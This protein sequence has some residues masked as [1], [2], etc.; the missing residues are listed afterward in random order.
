MTN[1][2][3]QRSGAFR[4]GIAGDCDLAAFFPARHR[5]TLGSNSLP[6]TITEELSSPGGLAQSESFLGSKPAGAARLASTSLDPELFRPLHA[7]FERCADAQP[8]SIA[9]VDASGA[10]TYGGL[11]SRANR[12]ARHVLAHGAGPGQCVVLLFERSIDFVVAVLAVLKSGAA[13]VPLDSGWPHE[14]QT[15]V[16]ERCGARIV[17]KRGAQLPCPQA[18]GLHVIDTHDSAS[19]LERLPHTRPA[20]ATQPAQLAYVIYTSGSTGEPKGVM[21]EHRSITTHIES[22][23]RHYRLDPSD[24][25]LLFHSTAFDPTIEQLFSA[26]HAGASVRVRGDELWTCREFLALVASADLTVVDLPPRYL[27]QLL[28]EMKVMDGQ[29]DLARLRLVI[30]GGEA[31]PASAV[32]LW[33]ECGLTR[34]RLV[35]SYG[36]TEC[37]V[38]A[39]CHDV[40]PAPCAAELAGR[41]PIGRPH[42]PVRAYVLDRNLKPV[43]AGQK[44]ELCLGGPT[45]GRGYLGQDALTAQRFVDD[46]LAPGGRIYL[47]GDQ[48]RLLADGSIEFLGRFDRQVQVRGYRVELAEIEAQITQYPRVNNAAVV[49]AEDADGT[50]AISAFVVPAPGARID[51]DDLRRHL[52]GRLPGYMMPAYFAEI[53]RLPADGNGKV[54][55]RKLPL[56][57]ARKHCAASALTPPASETEKT[58]LRIWQRVLG[59]SDIGTTSDF[60]ELGGHSLMAIKMFVEIK[61]AFGASLSMAQLF[62]APD[63]QRLAARISNAIAPSAPAATMGPGPSGPWKFL[64]PLQTGGTRPPLFVFAGGHGSEEELV[65]MAKISRLLGEDQPVI[66]LRVGGHDRLEPMHKDTAAMAADIFDE[67]VRFQPDGRYHLIGECIGGVL[68]AAVAHRA[69][70]IG[71]E[72]RFLG[73]LDS[74]APRF[75]EPLRVWIERHWI[76]RFA[77][78]AWFHCRRLSDVPLREIPGYLRDRGRWARTHLENG[79]NPVRGTGLMPE[80]PDLYHYVQ[81]LIRHKPG[82][83]EAPITAFISEEFAR[84]GHVRA[85]VKLTETGVTVIPLASTHHSYIRARL[86]ENA[87]RIRTCLDAIHASS[88]RRE[89]SSVPPWS[90]VASNRKRSR[91]KVRRTRHAQ[92]GRQIR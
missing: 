44:G 85:W 40:P 84:T 27:Q 86:D 67:I 33:R 57:D 48:A 14:R 83:V 51:L 39:T 25:S 11:E 3:N 77:V 5:S 12:L 62:D 63:I 69:E 23:T 29:V 64:L 30:V 52:A 75:A 61:H 78:R 47:T 53:D 16:I 6:M 4:L 89:A 72:V 80:D 58:L 65:V 2:H 22:I 15:R 68:A 81:T 28:Q 88:D 59:R 50:G 91:A 55:Y 46:P 42:G 38:T 87:A 8:D 32:R 35:N 7:L 49:A 82:R 24:R 60:F 66:G 41:V 31:L 45:V 56:L 90:P 36:P 20:I 18:A 37:S 21:I 1:E 79:V 54:D 71:A 13:F 70:S 17:V 76:T 73:L 34:L 26:F 92:N 74:A 43:P 19:L 9:L 10:I